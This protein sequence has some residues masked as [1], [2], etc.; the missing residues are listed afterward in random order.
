VVGREDLRGLCVCSVDPPGCKDIDDALHVRSLPGGNVEVGVHIAD[1]TN[2]LKPD[3]AMDEEAALR[4]AFILSPEAV[5]RIVPG[6]GCQSVSLQSG[7]IAS[8]FEVDVLVTFW[9]QGLGESLKA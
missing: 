3:T 6:A 4:C 9:R 5:C 2:F 8:N 1:V 7:A